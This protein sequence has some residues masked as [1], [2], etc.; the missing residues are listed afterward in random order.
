MSGIFGPIRNFGFG[1]LI[2][3]LRWLKLNVHLAFLEVKAEMH[4]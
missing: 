4:N 1:K 2:K 3:L